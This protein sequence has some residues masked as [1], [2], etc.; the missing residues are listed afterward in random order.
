MLRGMF[1]YQGGESNEKIVEI[2]FVLIKII[3]LIR[4]V[5]SRRMSREYRKKNRDYKEVQKPGG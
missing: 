5:F 4:V 3:R 2:R 1:E